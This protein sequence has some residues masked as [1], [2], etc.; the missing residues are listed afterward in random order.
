M[1]Q[2]NFS[3]LLTEVLTL[4]LTTSHNVDYHFRDLEALFSTFF[5]QTVWNSFD[6]SL[7]LR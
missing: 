7:L 2:L 4:D 3:M 5:G 6:L 1:F